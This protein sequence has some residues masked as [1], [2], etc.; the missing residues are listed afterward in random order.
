MTDKQYAATINR[1]HFLYW[2]MLG[3]LRGI[4]DHNENGL[5]WL[6]GDVTYNYS[7]ETTDVNDVIQ[8]MKEKK[9]PS[10]LV[11]LTD[12]MEANP[13]E[14]FLAAG[15]F[16]SGSGTTGMAHELL[17]TPLP[18]TDKR[19][20]LFRVNEISQL[21]MTGVIFNASFEYRLFSFEHYLEMMENEGQFFYLAEYDGLPAGACM[22]QHGD[23]FVNISWAGTLPGYRKL[24]IAGH[25]IQKAERDAIMNGKKLGVLHGRPD[26]VGA[27]RRIGYRGY[28]KGIDLEMIS[29][30]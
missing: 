10:N 22:S 9:I 15:L 30:S 17:D 2:D 18:K 6:T 12:N 24:G 1:G 5:R 25:L 19:L 27:Y 21:K 14:A 11:F 26:A 13:E 23:D 7:V 20:N 4:E 3:K 28:S 29:T 16:K 8:R